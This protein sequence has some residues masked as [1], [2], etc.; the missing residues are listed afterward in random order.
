M[1]V[2]A[3]ALSFPR[4]RQSSASSKD[5]MPAFAG[6]TGKTAEL[7]GYAGKK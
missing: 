2:R 1:R 5:W 7:V 6:M 3:A 4:K